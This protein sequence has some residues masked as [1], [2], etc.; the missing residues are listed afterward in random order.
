MTAPAPPGQSPGALPPP[1]RFLGRILNRR[2]GVTAIVICCGFLALIWYGVRERSIEQALRRQ[3]AEARPQS[4]DASG[5]L[6]DAPTGAIAPPIFRQADFAIPPKPPIA[7]KP[8]NTTWSTPPADDNGLETYRKQ[9]WATYW[10]NLAALQKQKLDDYQKALTAK[11]SVSTGQVAA[12][13][14]ASAPAVPPMPASSFGPNLTGVPGLGGFAGLPGGGFG[15]PDNGGPSTFAQEQQK[16]A[17]AHQTGDLGAHDVVPTFRKP[18][19]SP[20]AVMAGTFIPA[21]TIN[22]V[23]SDG[24]GKIIATVTNDIYNTR[25]GTCVIIP[26]G[27]TLIAHYDSEVAMGQSRLPAVITRVIYPDTSSA[28]LG[29]MEGADQNGAAGMDTNVDTHFWPRLGNGLIAGISGLGNTVAGMMP[30]GGSFVAMPS[31]AIG[32]IGQFGL[33]IPPTLTSPPGTRI[34]VITGADLNL[35]PWSCNGQQLRPQLPI[36][37]TEDQ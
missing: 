6:K 30:F 15:A 4:A 21:A 20:Y 28:D 13:T 3:M 8:F 29:A 22:A 18:P 34:N 36:L 9:A 14:P 19:P 16:E 23:N 31:N 37:T 2:V 7:P 32:A 11:T 35:R 12:V 26:Q 1:R 33:S 25:D 24:P 5:I 27:S 10:K 17:F